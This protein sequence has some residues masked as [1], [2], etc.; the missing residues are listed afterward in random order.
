MPAGF[1]GCGDLI[2]V[3]RVRRG[4]SHRVHIRVGQHTREIIGQSEPARAAVC[5]HLVRRASHGVREAQLCACRRR[6][7]IDQALPPAAQTNH[8][9]VQ[10][11]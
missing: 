11:P 10:H 5:A 8:G 3:L 9:E 2:R 1:G 7:R 4:Q 6:N